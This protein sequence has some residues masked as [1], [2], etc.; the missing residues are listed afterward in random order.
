MFVGFARPDSNLLSFL[1]SLFLDCGQLT[2]IT[3]TL[4]VCFF[5]FFV[6]FVFFLCLFFV[7]LLSLICPPSGFDDNATK[8]LCLVVWG[9]VSQSPLVCSFIH[10][11]IYLFIYETEKSQ[12]ALVFS[13]LKLI[14]RTSSG[15][16]RG[17]EFWWD[18]W[19][20]GDQMIYKTI[21]LIDDETLDK[22]SGLGHTWPCCCN[23][24][25]FLF[26]YY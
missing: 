16:G 1:L 26:F 22:T 24:N 9:K 14:H 19:I 6:F 5:S 11:F 20:S 17:G 7:P 21:R 13:F 2:Y 25:H 10:S 4:L 3:F 23:S 18:S 12:C 15:F 8:L